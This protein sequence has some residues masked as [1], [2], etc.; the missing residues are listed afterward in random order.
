[1]IVDFDDYCESEHR[2]DL[3]RELRSINPDFR[4]TVFAIPRKGSRRF[5]SK[6][7]DWIEL[8]AHG[9]KH[10]HPREAQHWTYEQASLVFAYCEDLFVHGFKAPGWQISDETYRLASEKGWWIADHWE[11]DERRPVGLLSHVV[12]PAA[13]VGQDPEHWHGHIPDVCGNGIS[14]TFNALRA[15]VESA[16]SFEFVSE[17]VTPWSR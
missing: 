10:P 12:T 6:T 8:A 2:L 5:W 16:T 7:P 9:W 1:V 13:C 3:L 14:E 17:K 11:N 15:V 4:C